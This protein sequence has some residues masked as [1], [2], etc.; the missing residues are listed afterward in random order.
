MSRAKLSCNLLPK[1]K[2]FLKVRM[3]CFGWSL[4]PG[5][6][7]L[8]YSARMEQLGRKPRFMLERPA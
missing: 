6:I 8:F 2:T 1:V 7:E 3:A 5:K 4:K